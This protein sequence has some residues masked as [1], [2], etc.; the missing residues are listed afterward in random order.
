MG[1]FGRFGV[2]DGKANPIKYHANLGIGGKGLVP[3]RP[4]DTFGIGWSRVEFSDHMVPFL[5]DHLNLG[6]G[7]EDVGEIYYNV[8]VTPWLNVTADFQVV[9]PGLTKTLG[10]G[11][12]LTD[13]DTALVGGL[14]V[15]T[16]F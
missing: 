6:L 13:V 10:P 16:R 12:Q 4:L 11:L 5:R 8:A 7:H 14:R 9:K 15:Y 1:V 2:S 3:G